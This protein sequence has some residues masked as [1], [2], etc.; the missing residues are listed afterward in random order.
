MAEKITLDTNVLFYA[1]DNRSPQKQAIAAD[2]IRYASVSR[3]IL[4]VITLGEFFVST[5]RKL[6]LS[7]AAIRQ[8]LQDFSNLFDVA[9]YD[10]EDVL[11]AA[12]ENEAGRFE[13]WDA[14]MLSSAER[15]GCTMCLSEDMAD[16]AKLGGITVRNPFGASGLSAHAR[17][18]LGVP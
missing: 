6:T 4:T 12:R 10:R 14:V 15:A 5:S 9:S 13:F 17:A 7:K 3:A 1:V 2:V 16:G 11:L 18:A 8:H